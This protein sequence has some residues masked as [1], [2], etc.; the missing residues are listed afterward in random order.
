[1]SLID[2]LKSSEHVRDQLVEFALQSHFL[3]RTH[4]HDALRRLWSGPAAAG[5]LANEL[6]IEGAFAPASQP[7][8]LDS[9]ARAGVV[10]RDLVDQL[11]SFG[12]FPKEQPPHAHQFDSIMAAKEGYAAAVKPTIMV[13]AATGAGKTECFLLPLLDELYRNPPVEGEGVSAII[14][15][16]MNA[17]VTDQI[18]RLMDWL[19]EQE[20][21]TVFHFTSETPEDAVKANANQVPSGRPW[22]FRSRQHA[23][24]LEDEAGRSLKPQSTRC[25]QI[26]V[27]NYS[28]LEY[29]LCRPQDGV[30]F[31]KNLKT[32]VLDEAHLYTG[33]LAAEL[34]L[35]LRR[36]YVR[37]GRSPKDVLAFATSA[38]IQDD[39]K[40]LIREFASKL[41]SKPDDTTRLIIGR[42]SAIPTFPAV[43]ARCI[44]VASF[45]ESPINQDLRAVV[46]RNGK[47]CLAEFTPM[48]RAWLET[49]LALLG[50]TLPVEITYVGP[51]LHACLLGSIEF[52]KALEL[53]HKKGR[54]SIGELTKGVWG[55]DVP[56]LRKATQKLLTYGAMARERLD[57]FPHLPNRIH[58]MLRPPDGVSVSFIRGNVD[59]GYACKF[60]FI[61]PYAEIK[62][63]SLTLARER[64]T[65]R[66][67]LVGIYEIKDGNRVLRELPAA[68]RRGHGEDE[69][70]LG[71]YDAAPN[72]SAE[73]PTEY[74]D[75]ET[76]V[77]HRFPAPGLVPLNA[78]A[79]EDVRNLDYFW[80]AP[81]FYLSATTSYILY[82]MP[83]YA[84]DSRGWKPGEGR[85]LL[86]FSDNRKEA[87]KLG[88]E[89][90][91]RHE[92][93][94]IRKLIANE[95][96]QGPDSAETLRRLDLLIASETNETVRATLNDKRLSLLG[97]KSLAQI[98]DGI[99]C[100][101]LHGQIFNRESAV[102]HRADNWS[103]ELFETNKD[104]V[105]EKLGQ[106]VGNC[107][108]QRPRWPTPSLESAGLLKV[109]YPGLRAVKLPA[110][111]R[112]RFGTESL[113]RFE[114]LWTDYLS[115]LLDQ[116]RSRAVI[117]L[118]GIIGATDDDVTGEVRP[119]KWISRDSV[120]PGGLSRLCATP[121]SSFY[122]F[123]H[124]I[125]TNLDL[126][127]A[128][129]GVFEP[130]V[131]LGA[132]FDVLN[133][134]DLKWLEKD[135]RETVDGSA[136]AFRIRLCNLEFE[137]AVDV[138]RCE[139]T[140]QVVPRNVA[141]TFPGA[142]RNTILKPVTQAELDSHPRL[143]RFRNAVRFSP[144]FEMGIWSEEHTAQLDPKENRRIQ[145]L[146]KIG[147]RNLLSS[148]TTLE[149]GIDIGGLKG[150]LLGNVPPGKANYL[151]RAGR[152]G[153]R[154]DGSSLVTT[155]CRGSTYERE[156]FLDFGDFL[157]RPLRKPTVLLGR[158]AIMRR[159]LFAFLINEFFRSRHNAATGA[160]TAYQKM[161]LFC[162]VPEIMR[163]VS[164]TQVL[165]PRSHLMPIYPE[166][167]NWL[168]E[169]DP[170]AFVRSL[171]LLCAGNDG[172]S[173]RVYADC[174]LSLIADLRL[175]LK[176]AVSIWCKDYNN[177]VES[178]VAIRKELHTS[179]SSVSSVIR[180]L[181]AIHAQAK[182]LFSETTISS[183]SDAGVLP[184]YGFPIGLNSLKVVEPDSIWGGADNAE[185]K[186]KL[187]RSSLQALREYV[188]G[189][190]ILVGGRYV[191]SS[192]LL[193]HWTGRAQSRADDF[194]LGAQ[195]IFAIVNG[196]LVRE[197]RTPNLE[198][199][200]PEGNVDVSGV[201]LIPRHG[202]TTA[203]S[204]PPSYHG[205]VNTVGHIRLLLGGVSV[206]LP[207]ASVWGFGGTSNLSCIFDPEVEIFGLSSGEY[208]R[209]Y[210]ICHSCGYSESERVSARPGDPT[211][212][213]STNFRFHAPLSS[214]SSRRCMMPAH[215]TVLRNIH[216]GADQ[217]THACIFKLRHEF[218]GYGQN[219]LN[220]MAQA[221][222]LAACRLLEL[223]IREISILEADASNDIVVFES[224]AGGAGHLQEL[225]QGANATRWIEETKSILS[226]AS[227]VAPS[228]RTLML[229]LLTADCPIHRA[230]GTP[231]LDCLAARR[232]LRGEPF[233]ATP[234]PSDAVIVPI[235]PRPRRRV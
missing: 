157:G 184:R 220:A 155:F 117:T 197:I 171:L 116:M 47:D 208:D 131:L 174:G 206:S 226:C 121:A 161:G 110:D 178:W 126:K 6:W 28:M 76:G 73:E 211:I 105:A 44:D 62:G 101:H 195:Y 185:H 163:T 118:H 219:A 182:M 17:L 136:P 200:L 186:T 162:G 68:F 112:M 4:L 104:H 75:P 69:V 209:G 12:V 181:N 23:R 221:L 13:S 42:K 229:R 57:L 213:L 60:S 97:K 51:A 100:G 189:S 32:I 79:V 25:P 85:R 18:D 87:A 188:P 153:R 132:A 94:I 67:L 122:R 233:V 142:P 71:I 107:L 61:S 81:G 167:D 8:S 11:D 78:V 111:I 123:T 20:R 30:F 148:T 222:R 176:T 16:P 215:P 90:G 115:G 139:K 77:L 35:L 177:L 40:E 56:Y 50:L 144:V 223:D 193:L 225:C 93:W 55:D 230:D 65:G 15:Y 119:G 2:A 49:D 26:L 52:T 143:K 72:D 34:S 183:L 140:L 88:C 89:L 198:L 205:K 3:E 160:M 91:L 218:V 41:F 137:P 214:E 43:R 147:A 114:C 58:Y 39:D 27:T 45:A 202:Y 210:A 204:E 235:P 196:S 133:A 203:A 145:N 31:G 66:A 141:N 113:V 224:A 128:S 95:F 179:A 109:C 199:N 33:N 234:E 146:F 7:N 103:Q 21:I 102:Q 14:L 120:G 29:M 217:K 191:K 192:G 83:A 159:H 36:V 37:A 227:N 64:Q 228:E 82:E 70:Q 127:D 63:H 19:K 53:L 134:S 86:V 135:N 156:V 150:A 190:C 24:G 172:Y 166:I 158:D 96:K 74:Y 175:S 99:K 231:K 9:L 164:A 152:A 38:T 54:L 180:R 84:G 108:W 80:N 173:S 48:A 170:S 169:L 212:G 1:M 232:I 130:L 149:L 216:L 92:E 22:T 5:G 129:G 201:L 165:E 124:N 46:E 187:E 194:G 138:Y 59:Y 154:A 98:V 125:I 106:V 168:A 10:T 207:S 151:Q